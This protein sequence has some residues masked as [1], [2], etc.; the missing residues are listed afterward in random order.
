METQTKSCQTHHRQDGYLLAAEFTPRRRV[1]FLP[2][3]HGVLCP[4]VVHAMALLAIG[5]P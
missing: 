1:S 4:A 5:E 2:E 3:G